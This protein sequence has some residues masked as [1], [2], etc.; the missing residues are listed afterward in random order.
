MA[1]AGAFGFIA[2]GP[3]FIQF[4]N[5]PAFLVFPPLFHQQGRKD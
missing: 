2:I 5:D 1:N 4:K 3:V